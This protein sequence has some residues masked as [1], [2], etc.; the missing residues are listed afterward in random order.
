LSIL[1]TS[2]K[3][4]VNMVTYPAYI[5]ITLLPNHNDVLSNLNDYADSKDNECLI[6]PVLK[7]INFLKSSN[8]SKYSLDYFLNYTCDLD[9]L[10]N[11]S[12]E[13]SIPFLYNH[14]S[15]YYGGIG[16]D[17]NSFKGRIND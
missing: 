11:Q 1:N 10:R 6:E 3:V 12:L 7:I 5:S 15:N 4:I 16:V 17:I 2:G 8:S 13:Q 14:L 9:K